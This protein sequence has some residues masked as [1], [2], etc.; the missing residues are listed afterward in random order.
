MRWLVVR[1]AGDA[2]A[3]ASEKLFVRSPGSL[4]PMRTATPMAGTAGSNLHHLFRKALETGKRARTETAIGA[5][6]EGFQGDMKSLQDAFAEDGY[7]EITEFGP[8]G[9]KAQLL[10]EVDTLL[11][12][13][14][15]RRRLQE[16]TLP[17]GRHDSAG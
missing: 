4:A 13:H 15:Q 14:A 8:A 9:L 16:V 7:I 2:A 5:Y 10:S 11:E 1:F 3:K 12:K 6:L 17:D